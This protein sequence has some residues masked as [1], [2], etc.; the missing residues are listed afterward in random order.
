M[1]P[2]ARRSYGSKKASR[3]SQVQAVRMIA[4]AR[5]KPLDDAARVSLSRSYGLPISEIDRIF[6][7]VRRG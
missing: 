3:A 4:I 2:G 5:D 1:K 6:A 7:E